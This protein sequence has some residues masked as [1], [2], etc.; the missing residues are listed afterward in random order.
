MSGVLLLECECDVA[1]NLYHS[2]IDSD[3]PSAQS[4]TSSNWQKV[5]VK[6]M[7]VSVFCHCCLPE[8]GDMIE[9]CQCSEWFHEK[10]ENIEEVWKKEDIDY[11]CKECSHS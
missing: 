1:L 10:C 7:A 8:E 9:C 11:V 4:F 3:S 6:N 5:S 2:V